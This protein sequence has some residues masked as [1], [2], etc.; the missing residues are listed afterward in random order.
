MNLEGILSLS[1]SVCKTVVA[2]KQT[3]VANKQTYY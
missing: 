2:N 1:L 3:V